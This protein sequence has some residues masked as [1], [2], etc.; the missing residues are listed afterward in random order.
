MQDFSFQGK[1][2]VGTRLA[3][4]LP[5]AMRWV[6]DAPKCDVSLK[7][8]T[9][10]RKESYSGN[11]LTS[12]VL[13]KGK[14]GT[15]QL[16]LNYATIE[17][18]ALGLYGNVQ[19]I[20]SGAVTAEELPAGLAAGDVVALDKSNI[21]A[22]VITDSAGTPVTL[23][24]NTDYKVLN[25]AAG[26]IEIL[27]VG[28]YTQPFNAAYSNGGSTDVAMF[29]AP[30]P[31]RY[32]LLDGINTVD[33]SPVI[34]RLYRVKFEPMSTLPLI[35]DDFAAIDLTGTVLFDSEAALDGALGGF[36]KIELPVVA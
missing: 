3:G 9:S 15:I 18:L 17:N 4:G 23:V 22:L 24:A 12:A 35:N 30:A 14:D 5:G 29:T 32:V 8:D 13:D 19:T 16:T 27:N 7:A 31:E 1:I 25:A 6:G 34:M 2:Y 36:G 11:R 28:S 26:T 10:T 21:S 33:N 20:A